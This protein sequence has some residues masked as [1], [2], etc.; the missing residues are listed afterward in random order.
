MQYNLDEIWEMLDMNN[1]N[2]SNEEKEIVSKLVNLEN[3]LLVNFDDEQNNMFSS[4]MNTLS[5]L[6]Y[7]ERKDAFIKGVR[8]ATQFFLDA[9]ELI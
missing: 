2:P 8:F 7:L 5:T 6:N 1:N 9:T 3:K 4:L